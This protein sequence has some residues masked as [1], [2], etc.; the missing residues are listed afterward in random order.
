MRRKILFVI[1]FNINFFLSL[2]NKCTQKSLIYLSDNNKYLF[3]IKNEI[4]LIDPKIKVIIIPEF[5]CAFFSNV[6]PTKNII[7]KRIEAFY[8]LIFSENKKHN[9]FVKC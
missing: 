6:S 9:F 7:S 3:N 8:E 2:V 5:D 4:N 1:F